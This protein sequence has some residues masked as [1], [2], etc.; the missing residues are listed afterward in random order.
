[1]GGRSCRAHVRLLPELGADGVYQ[2]GKSGGYLTADGAEI[3]LR[4]VV[5]ICDIHAMGVRIELAQQSNLL[6]GGARV[7]KRVRVPGVERHEQVRV[8][9]PLGDLL[10]R[11]PG[12]QAEALEL[13]GG[14][15]I[16]ALAGVP[17]AGAGALDRYLL[18][19][20]GISEGGAGHHLRHRGAADIP[21]AHENHAIRIGHS[22]GPF[23]FGRD[24]RPS[25]STLPTAAAPRRGT[26]S[27]K[28]VADT[29]PAPAAP[30]FHG[31][32]E[33]FPG[34]LDFAVNVRAARPP[35]LMREAL[36]GAIEDIA[37]Y[38]SANETERVREQ[39][40]RRHGVTPEEVLLLAGGAE[41]FALLPALGTASLTCV[42][43]S[44]TEPLHQGRKANLPV[45]TI[46]LD[47]PFDL[48]AGAA[49]EPNTALVLGNPCNPT[50]RL[51][52]PAE[53]LDF[54]ANAEVLVVD[55]AFMD[56]TAAGEPASLAGARVSGVVVLRSLTKTWSLAGLRVGYAVGDPRL[57]DR[58][59]SRQGHWHLGTPQ[60]RALEVATSEAGEA[61]VSSERA[62][63][64]AERDAM[65]R[66]LA[67]AGIGIVADPQAP[68][69]LVAAPPG[70]HTA[71]FHSALVDRGIAVRRCESFPG[72]SQTE[73]SDG[74][75]GPGY[76]R[77]AVRP[78]EQVERLVAAWRAAE[79]A[80][81][82]GATTR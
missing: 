25:A 49:L 58:L 21:G 17:A 79:A 14:A 22:V 28:I 51:Y 29:S 62:R 74:G 42:M 24:S 3:A 10:R 12:I 43:P 54:G 31:D 38:P 80:V 70:V 36:I 11:V 27:W 55:E 20:P 81:R 40:A 59:A 15:G 44:F 7:A 73:A 37:A 72:L 60:L 48:P 26:V 9:Q 46:T 50:S 61:W 5:G 78:A 41:G 6:R 69:F 4:T 34:C 64:H 30:E 23:H 39:I 66:A 68:F 45:H 76:F 2:P 65:A 77:L 63:M 57:L 35:S 33:L 82:A 47:A 67:A 32:R 53:V 8:E 56:M 71:D 16:H 1:M 52:T 18:A 75:V 13:G 19:E